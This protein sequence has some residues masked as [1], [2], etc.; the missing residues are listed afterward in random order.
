MGRGTRR[1]GRCTD[2]GGDECKAEAGIGHWGGGV[3]PAVSTG[4][5][6]TLGRIPHKVSSSR[7]FVER[8]HSLHSEMV[9]SSARFE[10]E[11]LPVRMELDR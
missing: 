8:I 11:W 5:R 7:A 4:R 6:N 10:G 1:R 3:G 9:A 2:Q